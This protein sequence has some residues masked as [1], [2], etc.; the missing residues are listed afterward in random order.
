MSL[1]NK[2][3]YQLQLSG[4]VILFLFMFPFFVDLKFLFLAL[5]C[6]TTIILNLY[7]DYSKELK[8]KRG[9]IC[10][11][12]LVIF[13]FLSSLWAINPG[14]VWYEAFTYL[15]LL[16]VAFC[17]SLFFSASKK[18]S[19]YFSRFLS[20][21][22][23][24]FLFK[25]LLSI[26]LFYLLDLN[27]WSNIFGNNSNYS[28]AFL[29]MLFPFSW[30]NQKSNL[31]KVFL[32]ILTILVVWFTKTKA[33]FLGMFLILF[34][35]LVV[36]KAKLLAKLPPLVIL[37]LFFLGSGLIFYPIFKALN[38][39]DAG[40]FYMIQSS[41]ELFQNTDYLGVGLGN[42]LVNVYNYDLTTLVGGPFNSADRIVRPRNH[43]LISKLMAE[44]GI[45]GILLFSLFIFELVKEV[46][47]GLVKPMQY[48]IAIIVFLFLTNFYCSLYS[49]EY[50]FSEL[51]FLTFIIFGLADSKEYFLKLRKG[52]FMLLIINS[53]VLLYASFSAYSRFKFKSAQR[54]ELEQ[55]Y[56]GAL[57]HLLSIYH[58]NI[59]TSYNANTPLAIP[60]AKLYSTLGQDSLA[61][62]FYD[63]GLE[64]N[65]NNINLMLSYANYLFERSE[66]EQAK[67]LCNSA[68]LIQR[69][70]FRTNELLFYIAMET[71]DFALGYKHL[72]RIK[73]FV[74][75]KSYERYRPVSEEMQKRFNLKFN[76][77]G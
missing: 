5:F 53:I 14:L 39:V 73:A 70:N 75:M 7:S 8:I 77:N 74:Q 67:A 15:Q 65:P 45:V 50:H 64:E 56:Q 58:P 51:L 42:W 47:I 3:N 36:E 41:I 68:Y 6:Q 35:I 29:I 43:N 21:V 22:F 12:L 28:T 55:N 17:S 57:N 2:K 71:S 23:Y 26:V 61:I 9:H 69:N 54:L 31:C 16:V 24:L 32:I 66:F 60:I 59:Y 19:Y 20:L 38:L 10:W 4:V 37:S 13:C 52:L 76:Y 48:L 18:P 11:F 72:D 27:L 62:R 25:A 46:F 34:M 49:F 30:Y 1:F 33:C 44:L 40:R 63:K